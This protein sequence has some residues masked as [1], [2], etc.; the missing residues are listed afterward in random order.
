MEEALTQE[1]AEY[2]T[3]KSL[4]KPRPEPQMHNL[5][6]IDVYTNLDCYG[7]FQ[8]TA[9]N[10]G[11]TLRGCSLRGSSDCDVLQEMIKKALTSDFKN[12]VLAEYNDG[13]ADLYKD[14]FKSLKLMGEIKA[15]QYDIF[16]GGNNVSNNTQPQKT[17]SEKSTFKTSI[18]R[19]ITIGA[20]TPSPKKKIDAKA[21]LIQVNQILEKNRD[22]RPYPVGGFPKIDFKRFMPNN[23]IR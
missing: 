22:Y 21:N 1:M 14:L 3:Y 7:I 17:T 8:N 9:A 15:W 12:E 10:F 16:L 13:N 6:G 20:I 11:R 18:G 5:Y 19:K 2:L 23:L 4:N